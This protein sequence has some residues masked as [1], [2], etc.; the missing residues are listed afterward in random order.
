MPELSDA[1]LDGRKAACAL[2][3][4]TPAAVSRGTERAGVALLRFCWRS[5]FAGRGS[6]LLLLD[7]GGPAAEEVERFV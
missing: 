6:G 5:G 4:T 7:G 3:R 2:V 1:C